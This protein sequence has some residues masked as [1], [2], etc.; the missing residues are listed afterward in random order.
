MSK[1]IFGASS[2]ASPET[3]ASTVEKT[4]KPEGSKRSYGFATKNLRLY[5]DK[6]SEDLYRFKKIS[7][8]YMR[9]SSPT[10]DE[11]EE[12]KSVAASGTGAFAIEVKDSDDDKSDE[13]S[14]G[15]A[16]SKHKRSSKK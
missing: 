2:D 3:G 8:D 15:A 5:S 13:E 12:D 1:V 16:S 14:T 10:R 7:S 11:A 6:N 9:S 4:N